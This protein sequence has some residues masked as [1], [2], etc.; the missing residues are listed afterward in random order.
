MNVHEG[1]Q[2]I[3]KDLNPI[4]LLPGMVVSNEPGIML[5]VNMEF[6][7]RF[8]SSQRMEENGMESIL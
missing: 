8:N 3:R 6:A 7:M 1:P 5:K 2:N 4:Q